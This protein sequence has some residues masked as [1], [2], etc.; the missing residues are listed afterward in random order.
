[1]RLRLLALAVSVS[2]LFMTVSAHA[3]LP[4]G[5]LKAGVTEAAWNGVQIQVQRA[6]AL[7]DAAAAFRSALKVNT[8]DRSPTEWASNQYGLGV[9]IG[10]LGGRGNG[11]APRDA[12]VAFHAALEVFTR[13]PDP[14]HWAS[15]EYG[16]GL[17]LAG[18]GEDGDDQALREVIAA[19]QALFEVVT[20]TACRAD[21]KITGAN[22]AHPQ[23]V[24]AAQK[25]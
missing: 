15:A 3:S 23:A 6:A 25:H 14:A 16:L 19:C 22:L 24:L 7:C 8:R 17:A 9:A 21:A 10:V 20:P 18:V 4:A 1:M 13:H 12:V 11:E 5:I 2:V